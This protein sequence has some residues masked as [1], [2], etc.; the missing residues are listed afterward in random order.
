MS[1]PM[2]KR[3]TK[4]PEVEFIVLSEDTRTF[5]VPREKAEGFLLLLSDYRVE[6]SIPSD[7]VF[8]DLDRKYT[9]PG[10]ALQGARL[11]EEMTQVELAKMLGITQGDL[12]KMEHGKRTISKKMAKRLAQILNIDYRVF[13]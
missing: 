11:K 7:E 13:L 8:K 12:S 5:H 2:K 3:L 1:V 10:V 4:S 9:R 6:D